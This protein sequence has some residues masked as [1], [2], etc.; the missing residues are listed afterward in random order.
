[1]SED[2]PVTIVTSDLHMGGGA[3]D[4]LDDHVYQE[5]HFARFVDM[6]AA[7]DEGKRGDVELVINGDFLEFAQVAQEVYTLRSRRFWCSEQ[8]SCDKLKVILEGHAHIF[9]RL[10]AFTG[11][12]NLLTVVPG[13]HDVDLYWPRVQAAITTAVGSV[14]FAL[15]EEWISRYRRRLRI[16]HG[17]QLDKVNAFAN[18]LDPTLDVGDGT[19]RLEMCPGT[20]FMV[21]FVNDLE[22]SYPFADNLK[23]IWAIAPLLAKEDRAGF[24]A[25]AWLLMRFVGRHPITTAGTRAPDAL[26]EF[27]KRLRQ[28]A[29]YD[30][31]LREAL[32]RL[33]GS[34]PP[35]SDEAME[36]WLLEALA[37][38][39][40]GELTS[41]LNAVQMQT[42]LG[43]GS[44]RTLGMVRSE[45]KSSLDLFREAALKEFDG[46]RSVTQF[47]VLGHTHQ[48]D[49]QEFN[50]KAYYN[51]G[52]WTRFVPYK[53][54]PDLTLDDLK[55]E[56]DYPYQLNYVRVERK[57]DD[58]L[59]GSMIRFDSA[60]GGR[61]SIEDGQT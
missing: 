43:T 20:L 48:P 49:R 18:W 16:S 19:R 25:I 39:E 9:D 15:G 12:R 33:A 17:H 51:T 29:K 59:V 53:D 52:S 40:S 14:T 38:D 37:R 60:A 41:F 22:R 36:T 30:A 55:R 21:K 13:N 58:T 61:F 23:P 27:P 11:A 50:G 31:V 3:R 24:L 32:E 42:T 45:M 34:P 1:M 44:S 26:D 47:V 6:L 10:K 28:R 4:P 35:D 7:T 56:E 2:R 54:V 46:L 57:P 8:E 5:N